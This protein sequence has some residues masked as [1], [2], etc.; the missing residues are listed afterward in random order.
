MDCIEEGL[1][2]PVKKLNMAATAEVCAQI[3]S[4]D[5]ASQ[6]AYALETYRRALAA[7]E[8]GFYAGHSVP[9]IEEGKAL[10][11]KDEYPYLRESLG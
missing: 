8:S 4:I 5:R 9:V 11:E 6:D 1:T 2:D 10:L 7:E 3:Y